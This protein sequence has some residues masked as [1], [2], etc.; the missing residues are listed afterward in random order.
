MAGEPLSNF[1]E[2]APY[3]AGVGPDTDLPLADPLTLAS[4]SGLLALVTRGVA[5]GW[6]TEA[7]LTALGRIVLQVVDG[8]AAQTAKRAVITDQ[9]IKRKAKKK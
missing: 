2:R 3:P 7:R 6:T 8:A 5:A 1:P 9:P 4:V